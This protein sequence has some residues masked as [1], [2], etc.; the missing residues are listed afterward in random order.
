MT[1]NFEFR[2]FFHQ[3]NMPVTVL[4]NICNLKDRLG[5]NHLVG[6]Q[7]ISYPLTCK[8]ICVYQGERNVTF[9]ENVLYVIHKYEHF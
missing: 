2:V 5:I 3:I 6:T 1:F 4:Q 8:R 7:N 9:S